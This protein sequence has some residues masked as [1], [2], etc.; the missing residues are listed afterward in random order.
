[1]KILLADTDRD[2]VS[3]FVRS[4][5]LSQHK[6]FTFS[7]ITDLEEIAGQNP[8]DFARYD[9]L[10]LSSD[11]YDKL[12]EVSEETIVLLWSESE[13]SMEHEE[14]QCVYKYLPIS[15]LIDEIKT[16]M[17][18]SG[19]VW[20]RKSAAETDCRVI[21]VY[22]ASGGIGKTTVSSGLSGLLTAAGY[23]VF[24]LNMESI[25]GQSNLDNRDQQKFCR[26]LYHLRKNE[27]DEIR[28]LWFK[29]AEL[30]V[31]TFMPPEHIGEW[32]EYSRE[33]VK[34]LIQHLRA[35]GQYDCIIADLDSIVSD[36]IAGAI[37]CSDD[38]LWLAREDAIGQNKEG[39]A[40]RA[41]SRRLHEPEKLNRI[42]K[43]VVV[44]RPE[45]PFDPAGYMSYMKLLGFEVKH[46]HG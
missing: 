39:F 17:E 33:D 11:F 38:L 28:S 1:M 12:P 25:P 9:A 26:I 7:I 27:A 36:R 14:V 37:D 46:A 21:A 13:A 41:L 20:L 43:R 6:D 24:Y 10:V 31:T 40:H 19:R 15:R 2:Y 45:K 18:R 42:C 44:Q 29:D 4:I 5:Q 23:R 34:S 16:C 35:T 30:G 32:E 8:I 22:S 3:M